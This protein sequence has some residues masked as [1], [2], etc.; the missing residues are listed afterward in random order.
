MHTSIPVMMPR[1]NDCDSNSNV[2][3]SPCH[4]IT[5][6][7]IMQRTSTSTYCTYMYHQQVMRLWKRKYGPIIITDKLL[8]HFTEGGISWGFGQVMLC[9][10]AKQSQ[11]KNKKY[12]W[13]DWTSLDANIHLWIRQDWLIHAVSRW[14]HVIKL[15]NCML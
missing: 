11:G 5:N 10:L 8:V 9:I 13:Q 7:N 4:E 2:A 6:Y 14:L 12:P 15:K 1:W 3:I